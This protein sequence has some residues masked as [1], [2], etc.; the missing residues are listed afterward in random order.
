MGSGTLLG[1]SL[2]TEAN[3][4]GIKKKPREKRDLGKM[5][6]EIDFGFQKYS[7][8]NM[9]KLQKENFTTRHETF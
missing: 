4:F 1:V 2:G 6:A 9:G 7:C 5:I 3:T 8:V